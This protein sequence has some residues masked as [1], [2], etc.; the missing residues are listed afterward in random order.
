[1]QVRFL[2]WL[3][4]PVKAHSKPWRLYDMQPPNVVG[5]DLGPAPEAPAHTGIVFTHQQTPTL[6]ALSV[7]FPQRLLTAL[8]WPQ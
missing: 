8:L 7:V 3:H 1:M 2:V 4:Q 6:A 5:R